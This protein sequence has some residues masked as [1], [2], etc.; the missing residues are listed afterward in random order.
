M[1][2]ATRCRACF[3]AGIAV[4][5]GRLL[6]HRTPGKADD[7]QPMTETPLRRS[8]IAAGGIAIV[9]V[10]WLA[11]G[12][13]E[14][15][16]AAGPEADGTVVSSETEADRASVRVRTMT[17]IPH[18]MTL[19]IRGRAVAERRVV[20]KSETAGRV[21]SVFAQ[22]GAPVKQGDV[23]CEL[24]VGA[25]KAALEQAR[26]RMRQAQ[27][28]YDAARKLEERGHR[29]AN[30][31]AAAL[32]IFEGAQAEVRRAENDLAQT[33]ISAPFD[34]Y[35]DDRMVEVGDYM[36]PGT[37]C[38][39]VLDPDP[40]LVVGQVSE[41]EVGYVQPGADGMAVLITGEE[42]PGKVRFISSAADN[43][44]RTFRME[45]EI[46]NENFRLRDGVTAEVRI[47]LATVPAHRIPPAILSLNA[48]GDVGVKV[49]ADG[50]ARFVPVSIVEESAEGLWITGLPE[51]A[52]I[53]TV[54]QDFVLDGQPVNAV[55]DGS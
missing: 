52:T 37:A 3:F 50:I 36:Q 32:A 33:R 46:P 4:V 34:G 41:R 16:G 47:T 48:N 28:D 51:T 7:G 29:S 27:L 2:V 54:G 20:L 17:A 55:A 26:A 11:S 21:V 35:V 44:T 43:A 1:R 31:T 24:D 22:K 40:F 38:A 6:A 14:S 18:E 19:T 9:A 30:Q 15:D 10:A 49:V 45:F 42:I 53:I 5:W 23:I 25:R 39:V 13:L 8:Y 12:V